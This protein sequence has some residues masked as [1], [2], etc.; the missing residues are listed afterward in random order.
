MKIIETI[1]NIC[2][3]T[4]TYFFLILKYIFFPLRII[5]KFL[6]NYFQRPYSFIFI[7][8]FILLMIPILLLVII[9]IQNA[10]YIN[11]K[12]NFYRI[13]YF[14]L[15]STLINYISVFHIYHLY[16]LHK[17]EEERINYNIMT[18]TK[19][20][21]SY[22]FEET[23]SGIIGVYYIFQ[24]ICHLK[25]FDNLREHQKM[26]RPIVYDFTRVALLLDFIFLSLHLAIYISLYFFMLCRINQSCILKVSHDIFTKKHNELKRLERIVK[27]DEER[28]DHSASDIKKLKFGIL[29]MEFYK[30]IGIFDFEKEYT[31]TKNE[32]VDII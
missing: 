15:A 22:L 5:L 4:T 28:I 2:A 29:A 26:E 7:L 20:I 9:L 31:I 27:D 23:K 13:F 32:N 30:F 24:F 8:D 6:T 21:F 12:E 14:T 17:L 25:L 11:S 1:D 19:F 18:Y 3:T 10:E 16:G